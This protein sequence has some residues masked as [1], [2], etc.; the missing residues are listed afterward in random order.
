M[1]RRQ[2]YALNSGHYEIF[3]YLSRVVQ[4]KERERWARERAAQMQREEEERVRRE[5]ERAAQEQR[6]A[7]ERERRERELAAN[8]AWLSN[9][10]IAIH[11]VQENFWQNIAAELE[12]A[13]ARYPEEDAESNRLR[14]QAVRDRI[15]SLLPRENRDRLEQMDDSFRYRKLSITFHPD[16]SQSDPGLRPYAERIF[17][18]LNE[19]YNSRS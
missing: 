17:K 11:D 2:E 1:K 9:H 4:Q 6:E 13:M 15:E 7:E 10:A 14:W 18:I 5:Q 3:R 19:A 12:G 8:R 16:K